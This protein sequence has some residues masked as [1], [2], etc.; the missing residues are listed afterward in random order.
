MTGNYPIK[1]KKSAMLCESE[2][3]TKHQALQQAIN[4]TGSQEKLS[5][6]IGTSA[7]QIQN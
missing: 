4:I 3:A 5:N 7:S 6:L 1:R 2:H